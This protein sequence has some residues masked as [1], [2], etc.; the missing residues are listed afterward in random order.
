MGPSVSHHLVNGIA[1]MGGGTAEFVTS[2]Q[3]LQ[4][5]VIRQLKNAVGMALDDVE[6]TWHFTEGEV[7][8]IAIVVDA[9]FE[10]ENCACVII[11]ARRSN[12]GKF[13]LYKPELWK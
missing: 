13:D 10:F 2:E 4:R 9:T 12:I 11:I 6:V 5:S 3:R 7:S 1:R 8:T